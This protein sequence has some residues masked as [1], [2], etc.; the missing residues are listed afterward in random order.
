MCSTDD[1]KKACRPLQKRAGRTPRPVRNA[2]HWDWQR[3]IPFGLPLASF[4]ASGE[5][6]FL[7]GRRRASART[8][9][10]DKPVHQTTKNTALR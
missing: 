4:L 1:L 7:T 3:P 2:L 8:L 10:A 5:L 6:A 9:M